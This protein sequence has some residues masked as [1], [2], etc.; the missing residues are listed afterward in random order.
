[1][2][3]LQGGLCNFYMQW[4]D[5]S[6]L[7]LIQCHQAYQPYSQQHDCVTKKGYGAVLHMK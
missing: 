4:P 5:V 7:T 1:M 6:V 2:A 3:A